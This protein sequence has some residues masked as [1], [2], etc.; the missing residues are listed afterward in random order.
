MAGRRCSSK[1]CTT[2]QCKQED[3][4]DSSDVHSRLGSSFSGEQVIV[5]ALVYVLIAEQMSVN[6][7]LVGEVELMPID[8]RVGLVLPQGKVGSEDAVPESVSSVF[9]GTTPRRTA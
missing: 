2:D 8:F 6:G 9:Q 1:A 3:N 4:G 5:A 7:N